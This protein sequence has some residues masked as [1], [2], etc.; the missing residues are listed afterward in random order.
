MQDPLYTSSYTSACHHPL[1]S[2][3]AISTMS[4]LSVHNDEQVDQHWTEEGAVNINHGND[5]DGNDVISN[6]FFDNENNHQ[7]FDDDDHHQF[8][9]LCHLA[10]EAEMTV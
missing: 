6:Q 8:F 9:V 5:D 2:L 4:S 3:Q 1:S 7:F 10:L